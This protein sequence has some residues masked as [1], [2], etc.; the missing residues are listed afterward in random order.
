M[1]LEKASSWLSAMILPIA[2][3]CPARKS[4]SMTM[5][6]SLAVRSLKHLQ[7][8]PPQNFLCNDIRF[9]P[10]PCEKRN[11]VQE[12]VSI[13]FTYVVIYGQSVREPDCFVVGISCCAGITK[14]EEHVLLWVVGEGTAREGWEC[15]CGNE[16]E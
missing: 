7:L 4:F 5:L 1:F 15:L 2:F 16:C 6:S 13:S 9:L 14:G 10:V 11:A 12:G 8:Q 3:A